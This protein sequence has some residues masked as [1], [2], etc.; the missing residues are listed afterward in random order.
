[1]PLFDFSIVLLSGLIHAIWNSIAKKVGHNITVLWLGTSMWALALLPFIWPYLGTIPNHML[2]KWSLISGGIH[3]FYYLA[4]TYAYAHYPLSII[5]PIARGTGIAI[6]ASFGIFYFNDFISPIAFLGIICILVGIV[7]F[8]RFKQESSSS[9]AVFWGLCIG[10]T[11]A[12]YL[13]VDSIAIR[14]VPPHVLNITL[15]FVMN[16]ILLPYF[17]IAKKD[18]LRKSVSQ[19]KWHSCL[20]GAGSLGSY[21]L[22]LF[23]LQHN[24]LSYVVSLRETS[25]VFAGILSWVYLKESVPLSRWMSIGLLCFGAIALK[26]G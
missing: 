14:D 9:L 12:A 17:L 3:V 7:L 1:M 15:V 25:I 6:A 8:H 23:I 2:L 16:L 11:I 19:H 26:F 24:P 20:I 22:L 5:Y 21:F 13:I 4:L 10:V 18:Q